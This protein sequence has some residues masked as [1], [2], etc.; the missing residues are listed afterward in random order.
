MLKTEIYIRTGDKVS[1]ENHCNMIL[2]LNPNNDFASCT[3]AELLLQKDEYTA[4]I[5]QFKKLLMEKPNNYGI[6][7]KLVDFY[8]RTFQLDEAK[9]FIDR[10]EKAATNTNDP[11]LCYCRGLYYKFNRSPKEA[12]SEFNKAKKSVSYAEESLVNMI[13]IYLSPD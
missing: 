11:G 2:K 13:D 9:K 3:L 10:A 12:L 6:L 4:A 7:A 5:E 1:S 8:R